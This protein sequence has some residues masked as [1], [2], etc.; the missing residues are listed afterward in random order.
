MTLVLAF[1]VQGVV[2]AQTLSGGPDSTSVGTAAS[3]GTLVIYSSDG[4]EKRSF[5]FQVDG[6]EDGNEITI[7]GLTNATINDIDI[8]NAAI[9]DS[10][11]GGG[12][13]ISSGVITFDAPDRDLNGDGDAI[14]FF[15]VTATG[16]DLNGDGD[17]TDVVNGISE[18]TAGDETIVGLD[19]N[20]D[21]DETDKLTLGTI[22]ET[23]VEDIDW[24][25]SGSITVE[26]TT[27]DYGL[28]ELNV[29]D[30]GTNDGNTSDHFM[31]RTYVVRDN[32]QALSSSIDSS[33]PTT[34]MRRISVINI[35]TDA[36]QWTQ[37]NL[38]I[39]GGQFVFNR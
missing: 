20:G 35:D 1:G 30:I 24:T 18:A 5:T 31:I 3:Q 33:T 29:T 22:N 16:V 21:G 36:D 39:S 34:P 38:R 15:T 37:V 25:W 19:L 32:N 14:D 26:Y 28:S 23:V 17:T 7:G 9:G 2:D 11:D 6:V 4:T 10:V 8:P 27:N 12:V 13:N